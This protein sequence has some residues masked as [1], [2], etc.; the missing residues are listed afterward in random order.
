MTINC[1]KMSF[2]D[3]KTEWNAS[4]TPADMV[5]LSSIF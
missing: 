5:G 4:G 2:S 1:P 3:W